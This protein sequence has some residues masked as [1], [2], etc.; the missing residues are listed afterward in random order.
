MG[1]F[2]SKVPFPNPKVVSR[3]NRL[4][5]ISAADAVGRGFR[6]RIKKP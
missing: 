6:H 3:F 4:W 1:L 2:I 5:V